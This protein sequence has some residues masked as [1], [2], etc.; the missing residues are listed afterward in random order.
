MKLE[1]QILKLEQLNDEEK[2][3]TLDV[4]QGNTAADRMD[5]LSEFIKMKA[6]DESRKIPKT[7]IDYYV[8]QII[9]DKGVFTW[10]LNP[11]TGNKMETF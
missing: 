3:K 2:Q 8:E 7:I 4:S 6:F 11:V 1:A 9:Y 10:I 5:K